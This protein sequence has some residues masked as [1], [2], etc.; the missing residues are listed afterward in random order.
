[1]NFFDISAPWA[2][3]PEYLLRIDALASEHMKASASNPQAAAQRFAAPATPG[4]VV[5]DG[6]A[7]VDLTGPLTKGY[8]WITALM[9]GTS[10]QQAG[11]L[12]EQ[13][14]ADPAVRGILLRIDSP[15][16]S[17]DGTEGLARVIREAAAQKQVLALAGGTIASAAYWVGSAASAVYL[18]S[19]TTAAGSIGVVTKHVDVSALESRIGIK[20]TEITS[21]KFKRIAS[22]HEPLSEAGRNSIQSQLD[23]IYSLFVH[24]VAAH[25]GASVQTV[26]DRMADGRVFIGQ[27][28]IIAGLADGF[29]TAPELIARLRAGQ[30]TPQKPTPERK[31]AMSMNMTMN[32][33]KN[34]AVAEVGP[35]GTPEQYQAAVT[36]IMLTAPKESKPEPRCPTTGLTLEEKVEKAQA[37]AKEHSV[38]LVDALKELGYAK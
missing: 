11:A 14:A 36:R 37:Y 5:S 10:M 17:V 22:M 23:H 38:E 15:G 34:A 7:V 19:G 30:K 21:G 9:G 18:E 16:G 33:I 26:L 4:R 8:S 29:A 13:A 31:T 1:M 24:A 6:V 28:A 27:Q 2:I 35:N 25:R 32:E 20:T 12:I 3:Q